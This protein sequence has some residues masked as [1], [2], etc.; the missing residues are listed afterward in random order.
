M[1]GL[2]TPQVGNQS[3]GPLVDNRI[4]GYDQNKRNGLNTFLNKPRPR[5]MDSST[6]GTSILFRLEFSFPR[7]A[8]QPRSSTSFA[9]V[10]GQF[11]SFDGLE[12]GG[13]PRHNPILFWKNISIRIK[14]KSKHST[15]LYISDTPPE[16]NFGSCSW[17]GLLHSDFYDRIQIFRI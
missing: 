17:F 7:F 6:I 14:T 9:V 12:V 5:R 3:P 1:R 4:L 2:H 16:A 11:A 10:F 15:G 8:G 13:Q